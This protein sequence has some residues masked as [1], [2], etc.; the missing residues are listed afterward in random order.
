MNIRRSISLVAMLIGALVLSACVPLAEE[1][2][3]P[4]EPITMIVPFRAG[5]GTDTQARTL[6]ALMEESMGQPINVINSTGAG[7][8]VGAQELLASAADGH[9]MAF[10]PSIAVAVNP[11]LQE[12]DF[13]IEDFIVVGVANTFQTAL[14]TGG[15][16]PYDTWEEFVAYAKEN[17]GLKYM[18]LGQ[19]NRITMEAIA[20]QEGLEIE[21]VPAD[22][23]AALAPALI[24]GDVDFG[25]SGGIHSRFLETG[26][27]KVLLNMNASG[28]LMS[29]P[30]VPAAIDIYGISAE[31]QGGIVVPAGTPDDVVATIGEAL[32][33]AV[34]ADEYIE[35]M[36]NIQMPITYVPYPASQEGWQ[37]IYDDFAAALE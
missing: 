18:F 13:G 37:T 26:E 35:L 27:M 15:E 33:A 36:S 23:G 30:D 9:T 14:V 21:Y 16:A 22:G 17:P 29:T 2:S 7:G 5:G 1:G 6:A 12:L 10:T 19:D 31:V 11:I 8:T 4:S 25:F 20:A 34:E 32:A 3:Y 28:P 24:S